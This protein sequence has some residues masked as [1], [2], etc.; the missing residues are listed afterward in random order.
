MTKVYRSIVLLMA[1]VYTFY[2]FLP[3]FWAQIYNEETL[4]FLSLGGSSSSV[5]M[6]GPFPFLIAIVYLLSYLG[7]YNFHTG[8]RILF[9]CLVCFS[10]LI[11]P[12]IFGY[13][14]SAYLDSSVGYLFSLLEGAVLVMV[15]L[16][17]ISNK[18]NKN[19]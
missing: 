9:T 4:Y 7:L 16:T 5:D 14:A 11:A 19:A 1:V 3:Y 8:A 18:F 6:S 13:S 12:F 10:I 17:E 2:F 15:Y